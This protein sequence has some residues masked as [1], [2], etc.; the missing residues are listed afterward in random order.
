MSSSVVAQRA[1]G[2][3]QRSIALTKAITEPALK[4]YLIGYLLD[5]VP[6]LLKAILR[7]V[8]R[9][10]KRVASLQQRIKEERAAQRE[11]GEPVT[12]H[13][14]TWQD[15]ILPTLKGVPAIGSEVLKAALVAFGPHG[16]AAACAATMLGWGI[17]D[18]SL[19]SLATR[20]VPSSRETRLA[21]VRI[22]TCFIASALSA[23][24][25][26]MLL[27]AAGSG[28]T[29]SDGNRNKLPSIVE[30]SS[31]TA[32]FHSLRKSIVNR[33]S[34][35]GS[36]QKTRTALPTPLAPGGHFL[37]RLTS[38]SIPVTPS[39]P[40]SRSPVQHLKP[41]PEE[42][43]DSD[44][45]GDRSDARYAS[46]SRDD[47]A[48]SDLSF[49]VP[50]RRKTTP[51]TTTTT[52]KFGK[53]SPTIDLTL[54]ALVRG[55]DTL[56]RAAPLFL[57][58]A[59]AGTQKSG[60][61][62]PSAAASSP[63]AKSRQTIIGRGR[64]REGLGDSIRAGPRRRAVSE[65]GASVLSKLAAGASNQAEGLTFVACCAVIMW[66]WFYAPDRLPPTYVKWITNLAT[67][68]ERLLLALRSI[69]TGK[70]HQ[71]NYGDP[72][73][74]PASVELLGSLSESL[75]HP[76]EW[77]DPSRLP[78]SAADARRMLQEAKA[79]NAKAR[80]EGREVMVDPHRPAG[81]E[82]GFVLAGAAGPRGR[83]EMGG[84]PCEIVHCGVGG[85][86]CLANA[87]LRWIRGWKVCMG[88]YVPVHL[89]PRLLFNPR[90]FAK[91]PVT[92]VSKVMVGSA[93][94]ASFLA[95]YIASIW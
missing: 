3:R 35:G 53:P 87:G 45:G 89:L 1:L 33:F 94:S 26:L 28:S 6:S 13:A 38:L 7:F 39:A 14:E 43:G 73:N 23:G 84:I 88:I 8:T 67:M 90:Q 24:T 9:Q 17:L 48:A 29:N 16:M 32:S 20:I 34:N 95:T 30:P 66:S 2:R 40:G 64:S 37:A 62:S 57:G 21:Q 76:Y 11:R 78:S 50:S 12:G 47:S 65:V 61:R 25:S 79:S 60:L 56:V 41:L 58:T 15:F 42:G 77:G 74:T 72:R 5:L 70:P 18:E 55:L 10:I 92:A 51:K 85:S 75:G 86:S 59:V 49:T 54:F 93:R 27:Q 83:G 81:G 80:A 68:D 31:P 69:R 4:A 91:E 22:W 44:V 63:A 19:A 71:W 52:T 82:P 36:G 46:P